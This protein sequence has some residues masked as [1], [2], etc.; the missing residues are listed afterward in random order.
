MINSIMEFDAIFII[1]CNHLGIDPESINSDLHF[2]DKTEIAD[3]NKTYRGKDEPTDVLSFPLLNL[4][5]G[6]IPSS[7]KFPHDFDPVTKKIQLGDILLCIEMKDLNLTD[8]DCTSEY[9]IHFLYIHGLLH[10]LGYTHD[11][12]DDLCKMINLTTEILEKFKS[13]EVNK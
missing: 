1:A 6:E 3:A 5:P 13:N 4:K 11:T 12:E 8:E 2:L 9:K 7:E 10:L